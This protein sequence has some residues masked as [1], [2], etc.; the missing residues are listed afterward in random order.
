MVQQTSHIIQCAVCGMKNRIDPTKSGGLAKCGKC[1]AVLEK[2][3]NGTSLPRDA[4]V[5]RCSRCGTKNRI[6]SH[7]ADGRPKCGKCGT[8]L[9]PAELFHPQPMDITDA[10]FETKVLRSPLPALVYAW[11]PW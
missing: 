1:G 10:D 9:D 11:A 7:K 5:M 6:P 4:Y 8:P 2:K 3:E